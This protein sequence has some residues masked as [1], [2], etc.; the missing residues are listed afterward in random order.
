M[1][2]TERQ[3]EGPG[4]ENPSGSKAQVELCTVCSVWCTLHG[5][6]VNEFKSQRRNF[7]SGSAERR[8]LSAVT[9]LFSMKHRVSVFR[10]YHVIS[11]GL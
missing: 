3:V 1:S 2:L 10:A 11:A 9:P 6:D 8:Q 7:L 5:L 4:S